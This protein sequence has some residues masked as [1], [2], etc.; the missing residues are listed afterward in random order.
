MTFDG[1]PFDFMGTCTYLLA[2][3]K[4]NADLASDEPPFNIR[5]QNRMAW[6]PRTDMW[7]YNFKNTK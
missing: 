6:Y 5:V 2:G 7:F 1:V 3:T 4:E